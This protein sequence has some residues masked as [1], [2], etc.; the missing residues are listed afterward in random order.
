MVRA[1]SRSLLPRLPSWARLE[2]ASPT[3]GLEMTATVATVSRI[4]AART[5]ATLSM[6]V[7]A[8]LFT[9]MMMPRQPA[10][11]APIFSFNPNMA[12][13]PRATPPTLPTLKARPPM[14]TRMAMTTPNPGSSLLATSWARIPETETTDQMFIWAV[15][16]MMMASTMT[17]ESAVPN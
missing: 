16:S 12:L 6:M 7:L 11:T 9:K 8:F 1:S 2:T 15:M 17:R 13:K 3:G 5:V 10:M 4:T 14:A